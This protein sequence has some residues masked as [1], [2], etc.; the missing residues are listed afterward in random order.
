MCVFE[1]HNYDG[2]LSHL[3][4]KFGWNPIKIY[5]VMIDFSRKKG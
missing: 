1:H 5:E 4:T 2:F 3:R